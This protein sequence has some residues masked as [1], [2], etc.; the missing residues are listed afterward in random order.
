[1]E[2]QENKEKKKV[3]ETKEE[4]RDK[5]LIGGKTKNILFFLLFSLIG[6]ITPEKE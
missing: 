1:M 2:E 3:W 4:N 5:S 6:H